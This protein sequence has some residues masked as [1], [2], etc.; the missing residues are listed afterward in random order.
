MRCR[1]TFEVTLP[2]TCPGVVEVLLPDEVLDPVLL[3]L[4]LDGDGVHA[5]LPA[6]VPGALP[7]PLAVLAHCQPGEVVLLIESCGVNDPYKHG[8]SLMQ[9]IHPLHH[10]FRGVANLLF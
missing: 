8:F 4:G 6:V 9:I 2:A 3:L 7:V 5:E 1:I 10:E